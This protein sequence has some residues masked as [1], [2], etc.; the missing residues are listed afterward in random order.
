MASC[1]DGPG[2]DQLLAHC[3]P[4]LLAC[5]TALP[6]HDSLA[7]E[8]AHLD[9]AEARGYF[10]PDEEE[11]IVLRYTQYLALRSA[12]IQILEDLQHHL[13]RTVTGWRRWPHR[14]PVFLAA[15]AAGCLRHRAAG[16]LVRLAAGR[17]VVWKKLDEENVHAGL[18]RK[19]FT[20]IYREYSRPRNTT[21]LLVAREFYR[22]H[23]DEVNQVGCDPLIGQVV[24]LLQR[25][26]ERMELNKREAIKRGA[27]Y[28]WFSFL[29]RNRM[30][31][32]NVTFGLFEAGGRAV[33]DL[34]IPGIKARGA[35]KR[36][37]AAIRQN[38]LTILQPGDV[39][40]TRH[41]DALSNL[42][43]PGYWP[44]AALFVGEVDGMDIA[45]DGRSGEVSGPCFIEAKKDGV[46]VR[47]A[48]E[49]F[50]VDEL[51]VLRPPLDPQLVEKLLDKTLREHVGK[52]YDF[53]FDFR[54]ADRLVCTEV[55]YR[56]YHGAG[57]VCFELEEVGGRLCLPAEAFLEQ[58][59]ACGF[60]LVA[61]AGLSQSGQRGGVLQGSEARR[62]FESMG[63]P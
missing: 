29:R 10:H 51:L 43:L 14:M 8:H 39:L 63:R 25:E 54:T 33:A 53:L 26:D 31:W 60:H 6:T 2:I 32:K 21:K 23:Q 7:R 15:Y 24:E 18:P 16:H 42:F 35:A 38:L 40:V 45:Q 30:A 47:C 37:D 20:H 36:I 19:S 57:P 48:Q 49:T 58:S 5:E 4:A 12:L 17:P 56:T 13:G 52:P 9:A 41:D 55:A 22:R 1:N 62:A 3:V 59:I 44:H 11:L 61:T 27:I 50:A 28:G 34:S 46:R